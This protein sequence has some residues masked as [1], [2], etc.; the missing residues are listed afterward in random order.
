[1]ER[2]K[3]IKQSE[4]QVGKLYSDTKKLHCYNTVIMR[5]LGIIKNHLQ[6]NHVSGIND[7]INNGDNIIRIGRRTNDPNW[8]WEVPEENADVIIASDTEPPTKP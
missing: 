3:Q 1:M 8:F 7:Y 5:Y 6:F 2:L 4:L